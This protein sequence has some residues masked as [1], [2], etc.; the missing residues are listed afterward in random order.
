VYLWGEVVRPAVTKPT[1]TEPRE[2]FVAF[3]NDP[4][5]AQCVCL[6]SPALRPTNPPIKWVLELFP[7]GLTQ[8]ERETGHS[9][10]SS[11]ESKNEWSCN[12][13]P[14]YTFMA[15]TGRPLPFLRPMSDRC[16]IYSQLLPLDGFFVFSPLD[17]HLSGYGSRTRIVSTLVP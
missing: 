11:T 5:A 4:F 10:P 13:Y 2:F 17:R 16:T 6:S 7:P 15:C 3:T 8:S 1:E 14:P 12:P 9:P